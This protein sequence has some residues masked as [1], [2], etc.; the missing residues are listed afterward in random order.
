MGSWTEYINLICRSEG[1]V[2]CVVYSQLSNKCSVSLL[3]YPWLMGQR[4]M[5]TSWS[6]HRSSSPGRTEVAGSPRLQGDVGR[7]RRCRC[8]RRMN[9]E[10]CFFKSA[11]P[12]EFR[13]PCRL[14]FRYKVIDNKIIMARRYVD[15][16]HP[17][18]VPSAKA[19]FLVI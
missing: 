2:K 6:N 18:L 5:A 4:S 9:S 15:R 8:R 16:R 11:A 13:K 17:P 19:A 10:P 3:L 1:T 14:M 12:L 7:Y